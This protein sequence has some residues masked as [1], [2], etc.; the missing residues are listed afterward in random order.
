[1][2]F[3]AVAAIVVVEIRVVA[4]NTIFVNRMNLEFGVIGFINF[5]PIFFES[6]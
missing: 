4:K 6:L 3:I 1:M 2:P 5:K